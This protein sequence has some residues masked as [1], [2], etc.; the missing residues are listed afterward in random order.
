MKNSKPPFKRLRSKI[1]EL[2]TLT[3]I[4]W[5]ELV[6]HLRYKEFGEHDKLLH[7]ENAQLFLG[8]LL[9]GEIRFHQDFNGKQ[10]GKGHFFADD[11]F[12]IHQNLHLADMPT[13][14][15]EVIRSAKI[16]YITRE[17]LQQLQIRSAATELICTTIMSDIYRTRFFRT[18]GIVA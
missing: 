6:K 9:E 11:F 18:A 7:F 5:H 14:R 1:E 2:V 8:F 10:G 13:Q 3:D 17:S 4:Q 16:L 12:S 15:I